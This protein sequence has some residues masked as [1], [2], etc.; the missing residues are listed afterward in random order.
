MLL[1]S[2]HSGQGQGIFF[3][4]HHGMSMTPS[5]GFSSADHGCETHT[6]TS[7]ANSWRHGC[8]RQIFISKPT[9]RVIVTT[10]IIG[11]AVGGIA[12]STRNTSTTGTG[13]VTTDTMFA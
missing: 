9:I 6:R 10:T 12:T 2:E 5:W 4:S 3:Q 7:G 1:I 11:T 8:S 13:I